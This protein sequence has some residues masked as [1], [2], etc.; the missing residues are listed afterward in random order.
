M[1]DHA[2]RQEYLDAQGEGLANMQAVGVFWV[3]VLLGLGFLS[4]W[5]MGVV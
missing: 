4:L 1:T 2:K 5:M 3:A